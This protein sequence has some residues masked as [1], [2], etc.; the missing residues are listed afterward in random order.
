[1]AEIKLG[2]TPFKDAVEYLK[3]KTAVGSDVYTDL[4][5]EMHDKAFMIAG[6]TRAQIASQVQDSLVEA[7]EKGLPFEQWKKDVGQKIG[8]DWLPPLSTGEQNTGWRARTIYQTN[9]RT[10]YAAGRYQ[11]MERIKKTHPYWRYRHGD[12]R[13]PRPEHQAWDG[14]VLPADD[15]WWDTH[16]P[17]NG[18][19]CTCYVEPVSNAEYE[20]E[21]KRLGK[22]E[23]DRPKYENAAPSVVQYGGR[24]TIVPK[25]IGNGW[26]YSPGKADNQGLLRSLAQRH[27]KLA[28]QAWADIGQKAVWQEGQAYREWAYK[29][30]EALKVGKLSTNETRVIGFLNE[31]A[32]AYLSSKGINPASAAIS[33]T[34]ENIGHAFRLSK[35]NRGAAVQESS[36]LNLPW[37]LAN[38]E[39]ILFDTK[40]NNLLYVFNVRKGNNREKFVVEVGV[41]TK[42]HVQGRRVTKTLNEVGTAGIVK[43]YNLKNVRYKPIQ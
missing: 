12:S 22:D 34:H 43:D 32:L 35:S 3:D 9:M 23:P 21:L 31:K 26:A 7:M 17:P 37:I 2:F 38:P 19:G 10:A 36:V 25:G 20:E 24:E 40:K 30:I 39:K 4:L 41:K 16:Y 27:P 14:V 15:Q 29:A 18:W 11:Q 8:W 33:I 6:V 5:H 13:V 42:V 28:A 1:M